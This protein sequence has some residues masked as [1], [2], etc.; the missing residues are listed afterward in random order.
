MENRHTP[1]LLGARCPR[2]HT[3]GCDGNL[4]DFWAFPWCCAK[5]P[6]TFSVMLGFRVPEN[7]I[8]ASPVHCASPIVQ[9]CPQTKGGQRNIGHQRLLEKRQ[10]TWTYPAHLDWWRLDSR[11]T[12]LSVFLSPL[13]SLSFS[14]LSP[15]WIRQLSLST[16]LY[17]DYLFFSIGFQAQPSTSGQILALSNHWGLVKLGQ[18]SLDYFPGPFEHTSLPGPPQSLKALFCTFSP[19]LSLGHS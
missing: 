18:G 15:L 16:G 2:S 13:S 17:W 9:R 11:G 3:S 1:G 7:F 10:S 5:K 4:Y 19:L 12:T 8:I 6:L 14:F